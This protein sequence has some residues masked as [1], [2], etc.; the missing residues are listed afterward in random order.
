MQQERTASR[1]PAELATSILAG[2]A[3]ALGVCLLML[4]L[5]AWLI[6][7][8]TLGEEWAERAGVAGPFLGCLIGG[9]YAIACVRGRAL[10]VGL[11]VSGLSVLLW[12]LAG[13]LFWGGVSPADG[14]AHLL[15]A[16]LG[17]GLAGVLSAT[18]KKRRK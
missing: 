1:T 17:G 7:Q 13:L 18:R 5:A 12:L 6:A 14:L 8:G 10:A 15:A 9:G 3:I 2:A 4:A 16:G 11:A